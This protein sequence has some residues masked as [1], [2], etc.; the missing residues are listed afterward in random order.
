MS[1]T[2]TDA[3]RVVTG[4]V[5]F[6]YCHVFEPWSGDGSSDPKFSV[7]VLIPKSDTT[8][9]RKI[10]A[11]VDAARQK[12]HKK[13]GNAVPKN[14]KLPLRDGDE[15]RPDYEEYRNCYFLNASSKSRPGVV[16]ASLNPILDA[17]EFY[18]G[19]YGRAS[20]NFYAF[21]TNGNNGVA[22]GL[23]NLQKTKD[24][25]PLGGT[26]SK[27]EDDFDAMGDLDSEDFLN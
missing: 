21:S 2:Q 5:R 15:E 23:N 14:L 17:G 27:P 25:E 12:G 16:D 6:S 9:L 4:T 8:T 19:C 22:V 20:L 1:K 7:A 3:T 26:R 24:G 10:K 18:S 13:W 11:A